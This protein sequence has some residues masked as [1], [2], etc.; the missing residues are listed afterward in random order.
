MDKL[1]QDYLH[2]LELKDKTYGQRA[3]TSTSLA[4]CRQD[5]RLNKDITEEIQP[6]VDWLN[7]NN[8]IKAINKLKEVLGS[9]RK[10]ENYHGN[11]RY[12][13]RILKDGDVI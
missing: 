4:K 7:D 10:Q 1:T 9:V 6:L 13:P 11:R 5:R 3:K 2:K 12:Y 8:N